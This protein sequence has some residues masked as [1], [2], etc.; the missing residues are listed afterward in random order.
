MA[1]HYHQA[2]LSSTILTTAIHTSSV[3]LLLAAMRISV[4]TCRI[5][6][7]GDYLR[8]SIRSPADTLGPRDPF[9]AVRHQVITNETRRGCD[10]LP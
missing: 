3:S 6:F 4:S 9:C 10:A 1:H 7:A 8:A 5:C 2:A